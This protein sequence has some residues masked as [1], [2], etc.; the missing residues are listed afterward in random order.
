MKKVLESIR[1]FAAEEDGI[2]LTEYL[3]LL[4]LLVAGV[5]SAVAVAGSSLAG[6]WE[7]W[8]T[9]WDGAPQGTWDAPA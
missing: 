5:I 8:G 7:G 3:V 2:A 6:A 4:G 1:A 9:F